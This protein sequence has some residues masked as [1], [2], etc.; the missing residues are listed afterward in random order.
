MAL[1]EDA[2]AAIN[3]ATE[4]ISNLDKFNRNNMSNIKIGIGL[5]K[6]VVNIGTIGFDQRLDSTIIS[7]S[8]AIADCCQ[9]MTRIFHSSI[10]AT[11]NV[12]HSIH[13]DVTK[14]DSTCK[15]TIFTYVGKFI[16]KEKEPAWN[17]YDIKSKHWKHVCLESSHEHNTLSQMVSL[18]QSSD[19]TAC[20]NLALKLLRH[21]NNPFVTAMCRKYSET[22]SLYSN[23]P[24]SNSWSGEIWLSHLKI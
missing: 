17:V 1:F 23:S 5:C 19:F 16:L 3:A 24:L 6:G 15:G 11:D 14:D 22:C 12:V 13:S 2:E 9:M 18:F 21:S 4:M 7:D 8:V 20:S 10:L